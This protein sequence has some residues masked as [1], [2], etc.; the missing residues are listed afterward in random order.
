[1]NRARFF[2]SRWL[3]ISLFSLPI[4]GCGNGTP[5]LAPVRG[6]VTFE[7]RPLAKVRVEFHPEKP[8]D[9]PNM[10]RWLAQ[11]DENG[12]FM[13]I[14]DNRQQGVTIGWHKVVLATDSRSAARERNPF[15]PESTSNMS[16]AP[17]AF[18]IPSAYNSVATTPERREVKLDGDNNFEFKVTRR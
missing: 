14:C 3:I 2:K 13:M 15:E 1:M 8:N 16:S 17:A 4:L 7:G 9:D 18:R 11:T 10:V 6:R 5:P 12:E